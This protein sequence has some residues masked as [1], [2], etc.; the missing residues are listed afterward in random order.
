MTT[1]LDNIGDIKIPNEMV[2][3]ES[4]R[5]ESLKEIGDIGFFWREDLFD[6]VITIEQPLQNLDK[7]K[8]VI[9]CFKI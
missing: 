2:S 4:K 5:C 9:Q 3:I 7:I 6:K 1:R 8:T